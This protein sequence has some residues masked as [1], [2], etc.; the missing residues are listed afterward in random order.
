MPSTRETFL[1]KVSSLNQKE[2]VYLLNI[3]KKHDIGYSKN[4]SGYFFNLSQIDDSLLLELENYINLIYS[5]RKKI[6]ENDNKRQEEIN[7]YANLL[8]NEELKKKKEEKETFNDLLKLN[9]TSITL[10]ISKK[11]R[12]IQKIVEFDTSE[13]LGVWNKR[14]YKKNSLYD[15]LFS[16]FKRLKYAENHK[17]A[18]GLVDTENVVYTEGLDGDIEDIEGVEGVEDIEEIEETDGLDGDIEAGDLGV[19]DIEDVEEFVGD[20][21]GLDVEEDI[22]DYEKTD[23]FEEKLKFYKD[24][25]SLEGYVFS[26]DILKLQVEEYLV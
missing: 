15:R 1:E 16:K 12:Y 14:K 20:T 22:E 7:Y 11:K 17:D 8:K 4:S 6:E 24:I 19:E 23:K 21:E 25:L 18:D 2:K 3:F 26:D 10:E 9:N 13:D 5:N